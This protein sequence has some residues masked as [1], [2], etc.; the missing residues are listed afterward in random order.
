MRLVFLLLP[1]TFFLR[2]TAGLEIN[3]PATCRPLNPWH[4][5]QVPEVGEFVAVK[6]DQPEPLCLGGAPLSCTWFQ[7][8]AECDLALIQPVRYT[9]SCGEEYI[10]T[11]GH[12]PYSSPT[13]W[14]SLAKMYFFNTTAPATSTIIVRP[15]PGPPPPLVS[16]IPKSVALGPLS[17]ITNAPEPGYQPDATLSSVKYGG[18][19]RLVLPNG[20]NY[21]AS[22]TSPYFES[23]PSS[24]WRLM[25]GFVPCSDPTK[26]GTFI[27]SGFWIFAVLPS[28]NNP[29]VLIG[30]GHAERGSFGNPDRKCKGAGI[31]DSATSKSLGITYSRDNGVTWDEPKQIITVEDFDPSVPTT[32]SG[33]GDAGYVQMGNEYRAYFQARGGFGVARSTDPLAAPGTWSFYLDGQWVPTSQRRWTELLPQNSVGPNPSIIWSSV[34]NRYIMCV[35]PW[36]S[37]GLVFLYSGPNAVTWTEFA[38]VT[39]PSGDRTKPLYASI[40][41]S[42]GSISMDATGTLYWALWDNSRNDRQFVYQSITIS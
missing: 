28:F 4:C 12:N 2:F 42:G 36:G 37:S 39:F 16:R 35:W 7:N 3:I 15:P 30:F 32:W 40:I 21:V 17:R 25:Y 8:R 23:V 33:I 13:S 27:S 1:S 18:T 29:A 5:L 31:G 11:F 9:L 20:K 38:R 10:R 14:C 19:W 6:N 41:G 26:F 24:S 34:F 22:H